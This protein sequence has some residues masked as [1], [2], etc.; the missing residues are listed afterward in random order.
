MT[1]K[2]PR[3]TFASFKARHAKSEARTIRQLYPDP[4]LTEIQTELLTPP[5]CP[6]CASEV[7]DHS[8]TIQLDQP[9]LESPST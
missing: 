9:R 1:F 3:S 2:Q 8:S 6:S 4:V 7:H 5:L